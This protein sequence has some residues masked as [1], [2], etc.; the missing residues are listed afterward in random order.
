M[1]QVPY[2]GFIGSTYTNASISVSGDR[3]ANFMVEVVESGEGKNNVF[4]MGTPGLKKL[5]SVARAGLESLPDGPVR[6]LW[7][8][9]G[10]LFVVAGAT[11]FEVMQDYTYNTLGNVDRVTSPA[12][13][14]SNGNELFIV[15]GRQG[16]LTTWTDPTD[17]TSVTIVPI[18]A[19]AT[20]EYLDTFFIAQDP[21]SN[22]FH[23]SASLDGSS[24][25][26]LDFA[27]KESDAYRIVST[28][29]CQ[30][31]LFLLGERSTEPWQDAGNPDFPF[32]RVPGAVIEQG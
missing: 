13:I 2:K 23:I 27:S 21:D 29:V 11:V 15:S 3:S 22:E 9:A 30:E 17:P 25:D 24:W 20:G 16:Y 6:G 5:V 8:G 26:S 31:T 18:I 19:A 4:L 28:I 10:R 7:A 12:Q 1:P 32:Q 14:F